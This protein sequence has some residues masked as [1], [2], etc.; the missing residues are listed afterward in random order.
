MKYHI[1]KMEEHERR[2]RKHFAEHGWSPANIIIQDAKGL[3]MKHASRSLINYLSELTKIDQD[4]YPETMRKTF[5][6]STPS[7]FGAIFAL[8][9]PFIDERVLHKLEVITS[10]AHI[11]KLDPLIDKSQLPVCI[12]GTSEEHFNDGGVLSPPWRDSVIK[13]NV[14]A[15]GALQNSVLHFAL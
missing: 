6:I 12:G 10:T 2:K 9:K 14:P 13:C 15:G 3:G 7:V 1:C 8:V 11:E 5:F 4:N